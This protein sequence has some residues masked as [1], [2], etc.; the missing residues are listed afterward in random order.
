MIEKARKRRFRNA[1]TIA[2]N[3][4]FLASVQ[5]LLEDTERAQPLENNIPERG[6]VVWLTCKPMT[7]LTEKEKL[8]RRIATLE[9]RAAS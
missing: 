3:S 6:L 1:N 2:F 5:K 9:L 7:D 8:V 4:Q